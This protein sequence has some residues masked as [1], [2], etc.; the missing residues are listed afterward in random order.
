MSEITNERLEKLEKQV[1]EMHNAL[2]GDN[3][4]NVGFSQRMNKI[5]QFQEQQKKILWMAT[6][7]AGVVSIFVNVIFQLII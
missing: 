3:Y 1:S 4:G 2:L 7:G 6:G 5:E